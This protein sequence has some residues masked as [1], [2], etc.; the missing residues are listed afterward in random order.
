M[1][2]SPAHEYNLP[3][4]PDVIEEHDIVPTGISE[5]DSAQET[6]TTVNNEVL[7]LTA[8]ERDTIDTLRSQRTKVIKAAKQ[9]RKLAVDSITPDSSLL[10][11][12]ALYLNITDELLEFT[13]EVRLD[14]DENRS[15]L[16]TIKIGHVG[17]DQLMSFATRTKSEFDEA[18][19]D[20]AL[21]G[22]EADGFVLGY[23]TWGN[24]HAKKG[25]GEDVVII[26]ITDLGEEYYFA[27]PKPLDQTT[28]P[29]FLSG[30]GHFFPEITQSNKDLS[31]LLTDSSKKALAESKG[32][33]FV[34][35]AAT[36]LDDPEIVEVFSQQ[37][38][39]AVR[40][41]YRE[42]DSIEDRQNALAILQR[43][44]DNLPRVLGRLFS[45]DPEK[46]KTNAIVK[47]KEF[48][49]HDA[50][51]MFLS[52]FADIVDSFHPPIPGITKEESE[53]K[54]ILAGNR[55]KSLFGSIGSPRRYVRSYDGGGEKFQYSYKDRLALQLDY[56]L[57]D[58]DDPSHAGK[59]KTITAL[60]TTSFVDA[61]LLRAFIDAYSESGI[62]HHAAM[63]HI[64]GR[65]GYDGKYN[66]ILVK[67][68][69]ITRLRVPNKIK[70]RTHIEKLQQ[71]SPG[72][73]V[74]YF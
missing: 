50:Q 22:L 69:D 28:L 53:L 15:P 63:D 47:A 20:E 55:L 16:G 14:G 7:D 68:T 17:H 39:A 52:R 59:F 48:F 73:Q 36:F 65:V 37:T 3:M 54:E 38:A 45:A 33:D 6:V 10:E 12:S 67:P 66:S 26:S 40:T 2:I 49:I 31:G 30:L 13:E 34:E 18:R 35:S 25:E 56:F 44:I 74:E 11:I 24:L 46:D 71:M 8:E 23:D 58:V 4:E 72:T 5:L 61:K 43:S 60:Y 21:D 9:A 64:E 1:D 57:G 27:S 19:L 70:D 62:V 51:R 29:S 32:F 41:I 42:M